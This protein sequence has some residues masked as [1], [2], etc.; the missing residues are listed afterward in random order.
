M[1]R[2][3]GAAHSNACVRCAR[4]GGSA[5]VERVIASLQLPQDRRGAR[6]RCPSWLS[7]IGY[8][9]SGSRRRATRA[10]PWRRRAPSDDQGPRGRAPRR[11]GASS[12]RVRRA[13]G[14]PT[15]QGC[16]RSL[17]RHGSSQAGCREPDP[18]PEHCRFWRSTSKDGATSRA[19]GQRCLWA[20]QFLACTP[21][22]RGAVLT[23]VHGECPPEK[24]RCGGMPPQWCTVSAALSFELHAP[25][26]ML[27]DICMHH[28]SAAQVPASRLS[29][30]LLCRTPCQRSRL[31]HRDTR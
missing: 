13:P 15:F 2:A 8:L 11:C 17:V 18:L 19:S 24:L 10:S 9:Y 20:R 3:L 21:Q 30:A 22:L 14:L 23:R 7:A 28:W 6:F 5:D 16:A 25:R 29:A 12:R 1:R 4:V 31:Q 27:P 26:L